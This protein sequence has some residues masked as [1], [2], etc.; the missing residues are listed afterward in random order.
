MK[1]WKLLG[2][3]IVFTGFS[4]PQG[5]VAQ[6]ADDVTPYKLD[7]VVVTATR[8]EEKIKDLPGSVSV[9]TRAEIEQS[10]AKEVPELL[11]SIPGVTFKDTYGNGTLFSFGLRGVNPGRCNKV[12]VMVN[13]V[14]MNS[15]HT[16]TVYWRDL[17]SPDQIE[18]IEVVKGPVSA[19]YGGFGIGGAVNIITRRGPARNKSTVKTDF[20]SDQEK[21]VSVDTG[22]NLAEK[23]SYQVGYTYQEGDGWRD[24]SAFEAQKITGKLGYTLSDRADIELDAGYV[25]SDHEVAGDISREQFEEDPTQAQ[26]QIGFSD[27]DRIFTN[28]VYRQ[29]IGEDD[30]LRFS[31]YYHQYD[32]DYMFNAY[33]TGNYFYD[34]TTFGGEFQ[35]TLNHLLF[36]LHNALTFGPTI[37]FD[38]A[39]VQSYKVTSDGHRTDTLKSDSLAEPMFW[40]IYLQDELTVTDAL[41]FTLGLR[42]DE[43]QFENEDRLN[44]ENTVSAD[45]NALSPKFGLSYR[46]FSHTTLFANV[47]KGFAPPTVSKLYGT[48]G[49]PDL[50]PE[51]AMNYEVSIR[52]AP[53]DWFDL[54]A[55][56]YLMDVTDEII[57]VEVD[58]ESK[59]MNAGETRHKGIETELNLHLPMGI[60][61]FANLTFQNVEFTDHK[62]YSSRTGV[63]TVYDGNKLPDAP[64]FKMAAGLRYHHPVGIT[65]SLSATYE[66]EKYTD[67]ANQYEI[68]SFTIWDTRL[69]FKNKFKAINYTIHA[70]VNNLFDKTYYASGS[71]A[72]V[73]PASP[74]TFLV[75][76]SLSY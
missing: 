21:R 33:T 16:G 60:S 15:G 39:D 43:A 13:G 68:P 20:G 42:Y 50:D 51:S 4:F 54:T 45:M 29:D 14:P 28:L 3:L 69:E 75:G 52:T 31:W 30:N 7:E 37:R 59:N 65:Y 76:I 6:E 32:L 53:V 63:T 62:V 26:T 56:A 19:L 23:F 61:P 55:A 58:G 36:G 38:T 73:Y 46:L 1:H 10:D 34:V 24:R 35:Y 12:L 47:A 9:V 57:S 5:A 66:D 18:R 8:K 70:A 44:P 2:L 48:S 64:D 40:A 22:G 74:R 71:G 27:L 17:P 41:K 67:E 25:S 72:D 49:N 11:Q